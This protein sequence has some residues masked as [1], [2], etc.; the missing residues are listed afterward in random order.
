VCAVTIVIGVFL[1][2]NR[3]GYWVWIGWMLIAVINIYFIFL[4]LGI[5]V[6]GLNRK[7]REKLV[8]LKQKLPCFKY[9]IKVKHLDLKKIKEAR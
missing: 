5:I 8:K 6:D 4:M 1:Y 3:F 9:L 2:Q 7:F